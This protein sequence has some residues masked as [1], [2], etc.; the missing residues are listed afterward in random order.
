MRAL[1][2]CGN[3]MAALELFT[4]VHKDPQVVQQPQALESGLLDLSSALQKVAASSGLLR[5]VHFMMV[6]HLKVRMLLYFYFFKFS[7]FSRDI[8][9]AILVFQNIEMMDILVCQTN[10]VVGFNSFLM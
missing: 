9:A 7:A 6:H 8:R 3:W 2:H 1:S 10:P 5:V 4:A